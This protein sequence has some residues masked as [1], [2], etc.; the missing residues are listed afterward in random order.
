MNEPQYWYLIFSFSKV[1]SFPLKN[2]I[3]Y[4]CQKARFSTSR[5]IKKYEKNKQKQ[6]SSYIIFNFKFS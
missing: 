6:K 4:I 2:K 3:P 5:L 1:K